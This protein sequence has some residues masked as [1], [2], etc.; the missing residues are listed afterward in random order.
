[1]P[2]NP[3]ST[4]AYVTS[5]APQ[6]KIYLID[7][8]GP[9]LAVWEALEMNN[10]PQVCQRDFS[11]YRHSYPPVTDGSDPARLQIYPALYPFGNEGVAVAIVSVSQEIYSG[12]GAD[13]YV[14][15]F[16]LLSSDS[17]KFNVIIERFLS[18]ATKWF[19]LAF[20]NG[21]TRLRHIPT[22]T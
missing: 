14:A 10:A 22:T 15:D 17:S 13:F 11:N 19:G 9:M 20:R 21:N 2:C 6:G 1:M 3:E 7:T 12:G 16:V 18:H 5:E 8:E 4:T